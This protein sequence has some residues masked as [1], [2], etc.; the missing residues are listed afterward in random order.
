MNIAG[1]KILEEIRNIYQARKMTE[2]QLADKFNTSKDNI[3][4]IL[5]NLGYNNTLLTK[6][7]ITPI[8][9]AWEND[10]VRNICN[11]IAKTYP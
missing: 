4:T 2:L 8:A 3:V 7:S 6:E 10:N 5:M 9:D 1:L 11:D